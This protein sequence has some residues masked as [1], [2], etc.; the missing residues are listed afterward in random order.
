MLL[1]ERDVGLIAQM[2]ATRQNFILGQTLGKK[3]TLIQKQITP[4]EKGQIGSYKK[5]TGQNLVDQ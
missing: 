2:G 5:D 4:Q 1:C 3:Q